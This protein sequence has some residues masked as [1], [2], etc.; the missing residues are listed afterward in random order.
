MEQHCALDRM[1][2]EYEGY[3]CRLRIL[4]QS[5]NVIKDLEQ[6]HEFLH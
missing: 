6:L 2:D 3:F 4:T 5:S 1:L